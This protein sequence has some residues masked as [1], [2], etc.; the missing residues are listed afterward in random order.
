ME[1]KDYLKLQNKHKKPKAHEETDIQ[2]KLVE[3]MTTS[4]PDL[5]FT[6]TTAGL[7]LPIR[8]AVRLK[9]MGLRKSFPDL[10]IFKARSNFYGLLIELKTDAGKASRNQIEM[11]KRLNNEGYKTVVCYGLEE[12][13][14]QITE[15]LG[16]QDV[17]KMS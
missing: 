9:R 15:Y 2:I 14:N 17:K 13:K 6:C 10:A 7:N 4:Y 11:A 8:H 5:I 16:K 3:W 1:L 12:A